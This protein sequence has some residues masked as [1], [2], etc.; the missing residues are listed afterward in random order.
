MQNMTP[1]TAGHAAIDQDHQDRVRPWHT[2]LTSYLRLVRYLN[3]VDPLGDD[4]EWRRAEEI[5]AKPWR[6]NEEHLAMCLDTKGDL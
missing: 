3:A 1:Y 2:D 5:A 4:G 6:W